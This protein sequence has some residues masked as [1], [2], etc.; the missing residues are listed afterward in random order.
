MKATML[1]GQISISAFVVIC[2]ASA[3]ALDA[4]DNARMGN[5]MMKAI[6]LR[7]DVLNVQS[8]RLVGM[9]E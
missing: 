8:G 7:Q 5:L 2:L 4:S 6:Q 1:V 9:F 3:D